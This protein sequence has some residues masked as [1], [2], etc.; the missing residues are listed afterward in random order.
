MHGP[1]RSCSLRSRAVAGLFAAASL[2]GAGFGQAAERQV[3][4]VAAIDS[5]A[6]L[7]KQLAQWSDDD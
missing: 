7:K 4:A 1:A 5:Y 2:V 3:L 6:D